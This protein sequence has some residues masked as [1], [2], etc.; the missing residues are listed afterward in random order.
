MNGLRLQYNKKNE[1]IRNASTIRQKGFFQNE[2]V[3]FRS[4]DGIVPGPVGIDSNF[5]LFNR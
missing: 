3:Q 2:I 4:G 5:P 1:I